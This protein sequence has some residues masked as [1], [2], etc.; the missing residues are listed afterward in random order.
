MNTVEV[1]TDVRVPVEEAYAFVAD[2]PRYADYSEHLREVTQHGSGGA[3]TEYELTFAWWKLTHSVR[4]RVTDT[5]EPERIDWQLVGGI[6]AHGRWEVA[7]TDDGARVTFVVT[8]DTDSARGSLDLPRL[9]S[10]DW[11]V[12][13]VVQK[14]VEEGER[15]VERVV[16]DLEGERR[17]V[18]LD[19][20]TR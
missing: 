5:D 20:R 13:R 4:S 10:M 12:E 14:V 18:D 1:S 7:E 6:D 2:F 11:V 9:V 8:Y 16:A 17:P 15:V 19:V 3:G